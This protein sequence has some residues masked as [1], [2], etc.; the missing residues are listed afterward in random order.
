M[1]LFGGMTAKKLK[2]I[3]AAKK[4]DFETILS[5]YNDKIFVL[6][7]SD[8][9]KSF[10]DI[11]EAG[12]PLKNSFITKDTNFTVRGGPTY[13]NNSNGAYLWSNKT[14]G[15]HLRDFTIEWVA[16]RTRQVSA[17]S[18]YLLDMSTM[19][20]YVDDH[21]TGATR[22]A[23]IFSSPAKPAFIG[24]AYMALNTRYHFVYQRKNFVTQG[25]INGV[26]VGS[27]PDNVDYGNLPIQMMSRETP[28]GTGGTDYR[29]F[30]GNIGYIR[31][32]TGAARYSGNFD[33]T[34]YL[35]P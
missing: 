27:T 18:A 12:D 9:N 30:M 29:S 26:M 11:I 19:E 7:N 28:V 33:A 34:P 17:D 14:F 35:Q 1:L 24:K 32:I 16:Y 13:Y 5:Q 15:G 22:N 6:A 8:S 21:S 3:Q 23:M 2:M 31:F 25:F 20:M 10:L 4:P